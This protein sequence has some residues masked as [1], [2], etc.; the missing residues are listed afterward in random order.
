MVPFP[1]Q[2]AALP[3]ALGRECL[4]A[5]EELQGPGEMA[6]YAIR[7]RLKLLRAW[8]R[9]YPFPR[10]SDLR[11]ENNLWK[12]HGQALAKGREH[13]ALQE[14]LAK[15]R[16]RRHDSLPSAVWDR[17]AA[18]L[19]SGAPA[20]G[21]PRRKLLIRDFTAAAARYASWP[22]PNTTQLGERFSL[23]VRKAW[24]QA[25][26]TCET[27]EPEA[28]HELRKRVKTLILQLRQHHDE[29]PGS[30]FRLARS[31]KKATDALGDAQDLDALNA[32]I[33]RHPRRFPGEASRSLLLKLAHERARLLEKKGRKAAAKQ[34]KKLRRRTRR[35][36]APPAA[37]PQG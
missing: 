24:K 20:L 7:K 14:A 26:K 34:L 27:P 29:T 35:T 5:L 10:A 25:R 30:D 31:L 36:D 33:A 15:L 17:Y 2:T 3:A 28:H 9:L 18:A 23:A 16:S 22:E 1:H 32:H 12:S 37:K 21:D 8:L 19:K 6:H 4:N 11:E 13:E